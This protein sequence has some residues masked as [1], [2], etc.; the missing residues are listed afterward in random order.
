[1][2]KL[3]RNEVFDCRMVDDQ[4]FVVPEPPAVMGIGRFI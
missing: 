3:K 1:M 2:P 4:A